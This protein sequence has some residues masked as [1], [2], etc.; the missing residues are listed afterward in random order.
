MAVVFDGDVTDPRVWS[1]TPFG[2]YNGLRAAGAEVMPVDC[3]LRPRAR[4][5]IALAL[6]PPHVLRA[7]DA[8]LELRVRSA[9]RT[10]RIGPQ[11][12]AILGARAGRR[13]RRLGALDG[14][15]QI[16]TG[17]RVP[18]VA[19][20]VTYEDMTIRQA[21]GYPFRHWTTMPQRHIDKR[22]ELQRRCYSAAHAVAMM[23][24]WAAASGR[25]DYGL[26][27][28]RVVIAGV[29]SNDEPR[30]VVRDWSTPRFLF[31]GVA[32][33]RKNGP[34]VLAAFDRVRAL[35]PDATLDVVGG[36]P[37]LDAP[38]VTGHGVVRRDEVG[39]DE[40]LRG[41]FDRATCFVM[42]S[43]FEP[44][45]IV[46]T[47]AMACGLPSIGTT[48]GGAGGLIGDAGTT[49][50]PGDP[51]ALVEAMLAVADPETARRLGARAEVRSALFTWQAVAERLL[52]AIS[53]DLLDRPLA[54]PLPG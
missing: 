2:V 46:Y 6:A 5:A 32:W 54:A 33:E 49:V 12:A 34:S 20:I 7:R 53:P 38:G 9:Y 36:H 52:G 21:L 37:P 17:F 25:T 28:D 24:G 30:S 42:P 18:P 48:V 1:G 19:P 3:S 41:L 16:G 26:P 45:G 13:I 23:S 47:E 22:V 39:G 8:T 43:R 51:E 31:I 10:A 50:D 35:W 11:M 29:G 15:V 40:L 14:I 27:A 44:A 4:D